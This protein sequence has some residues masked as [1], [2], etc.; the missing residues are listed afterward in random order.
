[1]RLNSPAAV[2][3]QKFVNDRLARRRLSHCKNN[4]RRGCT[5]GIEERMRLPMIAI[6][7]VTFHLADGS[8]LTIDTRQFVAVRPNETAGTQQ[9]LHPN[10]GSVVY[11]GGEKFGIAESAD[12]AQ[13]MIRNCRNGDH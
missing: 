5:T 3:P 6:C 13:T 2:V 4:F 9:R 12:Q 7:L 10:V 1:L 11:V 8:L